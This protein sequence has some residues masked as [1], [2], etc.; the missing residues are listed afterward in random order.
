MS[1]N[2]CS[3]SF[4][5]SEVLLQP[6]LWQ[7]VLVL[8]ILAMVDFVDVP[9]VDCLPKAFSPLRSVELR[10]SIN[11]WMMLSSIRF[12]FRSMKMDYSSWL[13]VL[14]LT[15][16]CPHERRGGWRLWA[17]PSPKGRGGVREVAL[18]IPMIVGESGGH[19]GGAT[20][21]ESG[22][23]AWWS[24]ERGF[25]LASVKCGGALP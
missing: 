8:A 15:V 6:R 24:A 5:T 12:K 2:Y 16:A 4:H 21:A 1:L 14:L 7:I 23:S 17:T 11:D 20:T 19:G 18:A 3:K 25:K 10:G 9:P 22:A 13:S